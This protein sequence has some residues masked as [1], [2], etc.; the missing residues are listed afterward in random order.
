MNDYRKVLNIVGWTILALSMVF[1]V[2]RSY[3]R[4]R[5]VRTS[6]GWDDW[7]MVAGLIFALICTSLVTAG[8]AH[9]LG[10]HVWDIRDPGDAALAAMCVLLASCFSIFS[11]FFTK[12][13]IIIALMR[14]RGHT[15][16]LSHNCIGYAPLVLMFVLSVLSCSITIFF[17]SPVE[18]LWR[19][20]MEGTCLNPA[21]LN[22][23]ARLVSGMFEYL[24]TSCRTLK[25][26]AYNAIMDVFC[27]V[28]PYL[29]I[30]SLNVPRK[31]KRVLIFLMGGSILGTFATVM[32][33]IAM[34][35]I[36]NAADMTYSWSELI[37]WSL[38][39]NNI[40]I[41]AGSFLALKPFWRVVIGRYSSSISSD[42]P[43]GTPRRGE[44]ERAIE[45]KE[46]QVY[47]VGSKPKTGKTP[48]LFSTTF[49]VSSEES[50][51]PQQDST[52]LET[53]EGIL[54]NHG[55]DRFKRQAHIASSR[56]GVVSSSDG[57][58]ITV[59]NEVEI[60]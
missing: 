12:S 53:I 50:L 59:T 35:S 18:K 48:N 52:S 37:I 28:M 14:I 24:R 11:A 25:F 56:N 27:A 31:D 39:E 7:C 9:G 10:Q 2:A 54:H 33:I 38:T 22:V 46:M 43:R 16:H 1:V 51:C 34:H 58:N 26:A 5:I 21:W 36:S 42:A 4:T 49:R 6:L 20:Q 44:H 55:D 47:N 23:G 45:D 19:P 13:S 29:V 17:C 60:K 3:T 15:A 30:R 57:M 40:F 41:I 8:T 32:K